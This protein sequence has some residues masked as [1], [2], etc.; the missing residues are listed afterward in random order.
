LGSKYKFRIYFQQL[1]RDMHFKTV[2]IC[3]IDAIVAYLAELGIDTS[4]IKERR[5]AILNKGVM[6]TGG[7]VNAESVV[8]GTEAKSIIS[9]ITSGGRDNQAALNAPMF[10]GEKT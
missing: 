7:T 5:T 9:R 8:A 4:D 2:E 6:I 1:D 3:I 10:Q